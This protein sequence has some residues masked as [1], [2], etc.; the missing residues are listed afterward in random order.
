MARFSV[1]AHYAL[2][3]LST[4]C[5]LLLSTTSFSSE[6]P[7]LGK[8]IQPPGKQEVCMKTL[9]D[10]KVLAILKILA[11]AHSMNIVLCW[12]I[13]VVIHYKSTDQKKK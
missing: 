3:V 10:P 13:I 11:I 5:S 9:P 6:Q 1:S 4:V 7:K 12:R 2:G 8:F